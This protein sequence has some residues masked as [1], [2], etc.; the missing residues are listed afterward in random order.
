MVSKVPVNNAEDLSLAYTAGGR[1]R[2]R[3]RK[4]LITECI[5]VYT[6]GGPTAMIVTVGP[7]SVG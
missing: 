3:S 7:R 2:S 6:K 4:T 1:A 5:Y